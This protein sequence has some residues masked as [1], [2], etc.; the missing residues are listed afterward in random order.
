MDYKELLNLT[1][2][3]NQWETKPLFGLESLYFADGP[4]GLRKQLSNEDP[5][6]KSSSYTATSFPTAS[7]TSCSFDKNLLEEM[8]AALALEAK[9]LN[10]HVLLGPG[11]NIKRSPLCGRNFE[12][13]SED[14]LLAGKLAAAY[15]RGVQNNGVGVSVKHF[16]A[17]NQE[18]YRYTVNAVIDKRAMREIYL[19]PF[20]IAVRE[21][22]ATIMTSYNRVNGFYVNSHRILHKV[23]REQW[24]YDGVLISDWGATINKYESIVSSHDLEMPSSNGFYNSF[25]EN[26][27]HHTEI[28]KNLIET[29]RRIEN[30][31]KKYRH[32]YEVSVDFEKQHE[33]A[34]HIARE[35]IVLLKNENVLPL[36][37][38]EKILITGP[39][40][41]D[42]RYQ[43]AGSSEINPYR[44]DQI[45]DVASNFSSNIIVDE[46]INLAKE[47]D[48]VVV[49]IGLPKEFEAEGFD[50]DDINIP[51]EQIKLVEEIYKINQNIILVAL[52]G[53]VMDLS[54]D[55]KAKGVLLASLS[56]GAG[57]LAILD[58]LFGYP[59]SGRLSET[60]PHKLSDSNIQI[61]KTDLNVYYDESIYV[62]YRYYDTFD[63][64]VKYPF[65]YGLGYTEFKYSNLSCELKYDDL[66]INFDI[67]NIGKIDSKEVI[68]IY[69]ASPK[70]NVYKP[71]K[72]L[73]SFDKVFLKAGEKKSLTYKIPTN[74]LRYYD[75]YQDI[76]NLE[77]GIYKV[78]ISKDVSNHILICEVYI[79]G[80]FKNHPHTSY[81][82]EEY[83]VSDF[84]KIYHL[85][86]PVKRPK[87]KRPY[88]LNSTL[89]DLE[90]T[91][92]GKMLARTILKI[93][94][95]ELKDLP[96]NLQNLTKRMLKTTPLR[97]LANYG[98][99]AFNFQMAL[100]IV[101]I[102][103]LKILKGVRKLRAK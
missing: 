88:N 65:G 57:A 102:A 89:E 100:G 22:P 17:N 19:K 83:D 16:F 74:D 63:I 61:S 87:L 77:D 78:Y 6:G 80:V 75:I 38:D 90:N 9:A 73:R 24:G 11:I 71:K 72:E 12:Y 27:L 7:L 96:E 52:G 64:P 28:Q 53:G 2:G 49:T 40:I 13:F 45:I 43:G 93:A 8:G 18:Q 76:Y 3:L 5:F 94:T 81:L 69:I 50:R 92:T 98:G 23:L 37:K 34:R 60:Y 20:E 29:K 36:S 56:G 1:E 67:E 70:T 42:F 62:G 30:L 48:K 25:V 59:P 14:P 35:S 91:L 26:R 21:N 58:I 4:H 99:D 10:V 55:K 54:V 68:Q 101:D 86:L 44:V 82:N 97:L 47:V 41:K 31:I 79:P 84:D 103:N 32:N 95:K 46:N 85:V 15:I 39:F 51:L 33:I 66:I